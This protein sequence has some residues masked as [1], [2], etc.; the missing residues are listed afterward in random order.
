ML[1]W[2]PIGLKTHQPLNKN[3]FVRG[4]EPLIDYIY[5]VCLCCVVFRKV[6][7][8]QNNLKVVFFCVRAWD[9]SVLSFRVLLSLSFLCTPYNSTLVVLHVMMSQLVLI[10]PCWCFDVGPNLILCL[11]CKNDTG[12][13]KLFTWLKKVDK[14]YESIGFYTKIG[15][16]RTRKKDMS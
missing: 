12:T 9:Y 8:K 4:L 6:R 15:E 7:G 10:G 1:F 5:S 13:L 2:A 16:L 11:Q 14:S 3:N